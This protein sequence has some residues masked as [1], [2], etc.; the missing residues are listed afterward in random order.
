MS[1]FRNGSCHCSALVGKA[2]SG[3]TPPHIMRAAGAQSAIVVEEDGASDQD[4]V[5]FEVHTM[6]K[7]AGCPAHEQHPP[8]ATSRVHLPSAAS[9]AASE[10]GGSPTRQQ[11]LSTPGMGC[12]TAQ[13]SKDR[14]TTSSNSCVDHGF[15]LISDMFAALQLERAEVR[16]LQE[17]LDATGSQQMPTPACSEEV[18]VD[19]RREAEPTS[20]PTSPTMYCEQ[21]TIGTSTGNQPQIFNLP[22][23]PASRSG[24]KHPQLLGYRNQFGDGV[25]CTACSMKWF[26]RKD[27]T[28]VLTDSSAGA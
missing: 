6:H 20:T 16:R 2:P 19:G 15:A 25:K 1:F 14:N 26:K 5:W 22:P 10:L 7:P 24:C 28:I 3:K 21:A 23:M 11:Q 17:Q 13:M 18:P 12:E 9:S 4:T 27:G 8:A